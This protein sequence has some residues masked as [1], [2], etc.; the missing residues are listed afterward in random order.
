MATILSP[1][2]RGVQLGR[3]DLTVLVGI[4]H[5]EEAV[6]ATEEFGAGNPAILIG[7]EMT[8][9]HAAL[10]TTLG[11]FTAAT[12]ATTTPATTFTLIARGSRVIL[13]PSAQ[14]LTDRRLVRLVEIAIGIAVHPG[15]HFSLQTI[16]FGTGDGVVAIRVSGAQ[17]H[18]GALGS[19][20]T[21]TTMAIATAVVTAGSLGLG[22]RSREQEA[23]R[24]HQ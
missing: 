15:E 24:P 7:V 17:H 18:H 9:G 22:C 10:G 2:S 5:G 20:G 21:G 6:L 1:F 4:E 13:H 23:G 11:A 14:A 12:A 16:D 19:T 8:T 3:R